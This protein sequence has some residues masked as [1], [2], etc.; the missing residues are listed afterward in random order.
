MTHLKKLIA[1]VLALAVVLSCVS[2][3]ADYSGATVVDMTEKRSINTKPAGE[4]EVEEGCSPVTGK[5]LT[6]QLERVEDG[7]LGM[8]V[9]GEYSPVL[10]QHCG[11][12]NGIG[13]GAP[14][15]GSFMD[16]LY[17]LP[18]ARVGN[19]RY[20]MLFN[21]I[22]P[23]WVGASRSTRVGY[24]W[25]RQEWGAPYFYIGSQQ[26]SWPGKWDTNVDHAIQKLGLISPINNEAPLEDRVL[27]DGIVSMGRAW[28]G[29]RYRIDDPN[30]G[31]NCNLV[32]NLPQEDL[33]VIGTGRTY[34]NH[35]WKFAEDL[36]EG[37]DDANLIYVMYKNDKA[38]SGNLNNP[39]SLY[40]F[41]SF[42]EYEPDEN[43]Y[44]RYMITDLKNPLENPMPFV[45][46]RMEN[47]VV[48]DEKNH[49]IKCDRMEGEPITFSNLILQFVEDK[50]PSGE[51]PHPILTGEGNAEFFMGG[52]HFKGV[53]KR[54]TY[55]D[56]TVF[57]G[58]DGQEIALQP[59]STYI[60]IVDYNI[61]EREVRYE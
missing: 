3:F 47:V 14:W 36:P 59:G 49:K 15:Y 16:V 1:L 54:E 4:N 40:Y 6:E 30:M 11:I 46:Q 23:T 51:C 33:Q 22:H 7:F 58:E 61:K 44:Y 39:N 48:S 56:R 34:K 10:V 41:N 13:I 26:D 8:A 24:L 21:D 12:C 38:M 43:V 35:A 27:F 20:M 55:E 25:I 32:W 60:G 57:Y 53:W 5:P 18:K 29:P 17:E 50:W 37:G 28:N 42:F 31:N 2:A 9:T 45:E 19:T 52:K